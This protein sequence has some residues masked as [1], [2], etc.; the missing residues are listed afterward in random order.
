MVLAG[1]G[2][3]LFSIVGADSADTKIQACLFAIA[4]LDETEPT[5]WEASYR[6]YLVYG[7]QIETFPKVIRDTSQITGGKF[8]FD[9]DSVY[10]PI[11]TLYKWSGAGTTYLAV[12]IRMSSSGEIEFQVGNGAQNI[13]SH[14]FTSKWTMLQT[15]RHGFNTSTPGT[16]VGSAA[17]DFSGSG[18]WHFKSPPAEAAHLIIE[19]AEGAKLDLVDS[20]GAANVKIGQLL[21]DSGKIIVRFLNDDITLKTDNVLT[22]DLATGAVTAGTSI[23]ATLGNITATD[24]DVVITDATNG[25]KVGANKVV[26]ARG[27]ALTAQLTSLTHTAPSTPDYALQDLTDTGGFGFKTKDEGNSVLAVILNL[28]TRMAELEARLS[29]SAGHGLFT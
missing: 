1:G 28:Q 3:G 25:M 20:G 7:P 8:Y 5:L 24:G 19:G 16:D 27:A 26:G 4:N 2:T 13:G 6:P 23:T 17:G 21:V 10:Y 29:S 12:R 18:I 9:A 15:G 14:T 22:I 11:Q